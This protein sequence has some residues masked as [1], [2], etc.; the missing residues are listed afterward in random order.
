[1]QPA[2]TSKREAGYRAA[3]MV[4]DGMVVGLGTGSTVLYAMEKISEKI[5]GGMKITGIP[6]SYQAA[7][8]ARAMGIPV[9]SLDD[10]PVID[11]CI[12]GADQ[13]DPA[14]RLIKGRGAAQTREK[15]VAAAAGTVI[16]VVD[17][18]KITGKLDAVV[19]VEVIPFSVT[20]V[21]KAVRNAGGTPLLREGVKKD[22]PVITDNG[23]FILDV[24]FGPIEDPGSLETFLNCIPGVVT[25]GLFCGFTA[26]T[27]VI[28]GG[29]QG[30]RVLPPEQ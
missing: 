15:C 28:I 29:D 1:M 25:C 12:D 10:Y 14:L 6:T 4:T 8:R 11:L 9:G 21:M 22:G 2:D 19:P 5:K 13:V 3:E 7:I 20:P 18:S 23:N 17:E 24:A 30:C 27:K 16:I 26:K